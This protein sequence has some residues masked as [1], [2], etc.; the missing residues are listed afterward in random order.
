MAITGL[1]IRPAVLVVEL[2]KLPGATHQCT[3]TPCPMSG[4]IISPLHRVAPYIRLVIGYALCAEGRVAPT[5][6]SGCG[7]GA[8]VSAF[9]HPT[10]SSHWRSRPEKKKNI[11]NRGWALTS[12]RPANKCLFARFRVTCV[13]KQK[14]KEFCY[15]DVCET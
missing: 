14:R 5:K 6:Q 12:V 13:S 11:S 2:A 7:G 10:L 15:E 3:P 1:S 8:S 4:M 9:A